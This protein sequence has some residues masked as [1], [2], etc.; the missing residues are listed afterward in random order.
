MA[1][2]CCPKGIT[3]Q[4]FLPR[5]PSEMMISLLTLFMIP[6]RS[7]FCLNDFSG[8]ALTIRSIYGWS[9][10]FFFFFSAVLFAR[11]EV[12][13]QSCIPF[14][15]LLD[16]LF[17]C[18][19]IF[20]CVH[21]RHLNVMILLYPGSMIGYWSPVIAFYSSNNRNTPSSHWSR[22]WMSCIFVLWAS[23]SRSMQL[24]FLTCFPLQVVYY[25]H[26]QW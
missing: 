10:F 3:M 8:D 18:K 15:S 24:P 21:D 11:E 16:S 19:A 14:P 22:H 6:R 4:R 23:F 1:L 25:C 20:M 26:S 12:N 2:R 17:Y 9:F 5:R 7:V 13:V